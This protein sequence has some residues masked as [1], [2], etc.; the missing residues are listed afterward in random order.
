MTFRK[1]LLI[2]V[3]AASSLISVEAQVVDYG[4]AN[5]VCSFESG[6]DGFKASKHSKLSICDTHSKLGSKSLHWK[7]CKS[8]AY[9]KLNEPVPY[10]PENPNPK[11]T[12]VSSFVFWIYS[13]E[14]LSGSLRFSFLK[15]GRECCHFDYQLGFK[16]W[17]GAWV[18][19]DRDMEGKPEIG[20]NEVRITAS[21]DLKKGS[22]FFDGI[23]TASFQDVRY[24]TADWQARFINKETTNFWLTLN[25]F[26][27]NQFDIPETNKVVTSEEKADFKAIQDRFIE[28]VTDGVKPLGV[29]EIRRIYDSYSISFNSDG[30]INGKPI[31]FIRY[32]E[33]YLNQGIPDAMKS[34]TAAGQTLRQLNDFM[35]K[36]A[37]SYMHETDL[38]VKDEI[39]K[40][41]VNLTRH[42]LDQGF[43][44][45]SGQ[46]TLHHLG[47][48]MRNFYTGPVIMKEVLKEAGLD[49]QMQRAMEWF[50]GLGEVKTAPKQLGMDIDAFNTS[51]MGRFASVIMLEDSPYKLVYMKALSRWVDNGFKYT[52]GTNPAFKRDGTVVHHRKCYPEYAVGGFKGSINA[53]W[54]LAKTAFAV[55]QESHEIQK[56]ALL[57][58]RFFS[59]L[60]S[61]PLAMSGRHPDG[62]RSFIPS[63]F[64][65]LADAGSPDG[66]QAID[67]E[68]AMA[69]L[70]I[71]GDIGKWSQKFIN[72]G[73]SAEKSPTGGK[74][75]PYNCSLSYR[76]ED[77]LVTFAGHSRYL[78]AAETYQRE[79]HYGRYL[80]HGS[81]QLMT[82]KDS[83]ESGYQLYGWDWCHIPGTTAAA[84]PMEKMKANVLN[85]DEFSG[86][87][88]M[89]LSDE[90]FAGGVSFGKEAAMYSMKL[91]EH[92][93]YNG[94]LRADKSFFAF[95][96]RIVCIGSDLQN[97]LEGSELHTTLF[98][99]SLPDST[100]STIVNG[101]SHHEMSFSTLL[102]DH[103]N[104]IVD[105]LGN[106]YFTE[107]AKVRIERSMQN[108]LH[109]ETDAPTQGYFEKAYIEH[110]SECSSELPGCDPDYEYMVV[111][112][113]DQQQI[114]QY[115]QN[116][117]YSVLKAD[118]T[119]HIVKD[120]ATGIVG[121]AAFQTTSVDEIIAEVSPSVMM[122]RA[123]NDMLEMSVSNPDLSLYQGESDEIFDADGKRI[124]RSV[125]G[126]KWINNPAG[127]TFVNIV[128]NGEWEISDKNNNKIS[129]RF[130]NERTMINFVCFESDAMHVKLRRKSL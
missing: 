30:T 1:I 34:F 32:G 9:I 88:E 117:P 51:L 64:A 92:D 80:T 113:A 22:L 109:E 121:C 28:L 72:A 85:V 38:T 8:G 124:E 47:Y 10:L 19:F 15:D 7:W 20:M 2:F 119:A 13:P 6:T 115:A 56:E 57:T 33:T 50:C 43:A 84:I 3:L 53:I 116:K 17:R 125:Y 82:G 90:W 65:L 58:M 26:W 120:N 89:L 110:G 71:N 75:L 60:K 77:W 83:F 5:G 78:W 122:Y 99:N 112:K 93:K 12:S 40:I 86:Y 126:R 36:V 70:R 49:S 45:G 96:D 4:Q 106:A 67:Q 73:Y 94:S 63:Q 16:G 111:V 97:N 44:A 14:V 87:E 31:W 35:L 42:V 69:Y 23:I 66:S 103:E 127:E 21:K 62:T 102:N 18:A 55:S 48:S 107:G 46:G 95:D 108:S 81:M 100:Y 59:Q 76:Q 128:L 39:A 37:V 118:K 61:F 68:L 52:E 29:D 74:V 79:N 24:H 54:M 27:D 123:E 25:Q 129:V 91:H 41:Y 105:R 114:E 98:Q 104:V 101:K 130:E 11:E